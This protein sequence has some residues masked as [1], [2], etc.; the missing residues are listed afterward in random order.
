MV[1][2]ESSG[3]VVVVVTAVSVVGEACPRPGVV[4]VVVAAGLDVVVVAGGLQVV[5][6]DVVPVD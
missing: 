1:P 6:L 5:V 2:L 3:S 4:V